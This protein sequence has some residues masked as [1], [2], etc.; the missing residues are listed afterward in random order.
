MKDRWNLFD[1]LI[2]I[3]SLVDILYT[4]F[5]AVSMD[6]MLGRLGVELSVWV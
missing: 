2:V 5:H 4:E 6:A 3:G 1:S